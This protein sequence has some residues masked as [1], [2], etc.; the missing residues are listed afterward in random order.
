MMLEFEVNVEDLDDIEDY[1]FF[2]EEVEEDVVM[3]LCI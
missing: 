1:F 2:V 3:N